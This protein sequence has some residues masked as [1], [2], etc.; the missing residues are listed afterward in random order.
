MNLWVPQPGRLFP[1]GH[2]ALGS[3]GYSTAWWA[4]WNP[5]LPVLLGWSLSLFVGQQHKAVSSALESLVSACFDRSATS[6][7]RKGPPV[8]FHHFDTLGIKME[9]RKPAVVQGLVFTLS[10]L[11][12]VTRSEVHVLILLKTRS[13]LWLIALN[14]HLFFVNL[15]PSNY[16]NQ[17]FPHYVGV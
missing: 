9:K 15:I 1:K 16:L 3:A 8:K 17:H 7:S 14:L 13:P 4:L 6:C 5:P 10:G 2:M 12:F 11:C